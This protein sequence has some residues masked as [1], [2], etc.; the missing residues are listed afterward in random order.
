MKKTFIKN[1]I[2]IFLFFLSSELLVLP[3]TLFHIDISQMSLLGKS[4]YLIITQIIYMVF[5]ISLYF[6]DFK[7]FIRDYR[8]HAKKYISFGFRWWFVG[9][10]IMAASNLLILI[11]TPN[12]MAGNEQG[13]RELFKTVPLYMCVST[14]LYAP[15]VEEITFRGAIK[16]LIK[17][18]LLYI[19]ISGFFFGFLHVFSSFDSL[20]N[21][22]YLIPYCAL[23]CIF[24]YAY[25][26]T[27]N[28][29]VPISMHMFHN[30]LAV[31]MLLVARMVS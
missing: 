22:L 1:L 20:W 27:K 25:H 6:N 11:L 17:N 19:I 24:A 3:L 7:I 9:Y 31:I 23:G 21:L 12:S 13:I 18:P 16:N 4:V 29:L 15:I 26:K 5:L 28:L 30:S 8:S 10:V 14:I 2:V